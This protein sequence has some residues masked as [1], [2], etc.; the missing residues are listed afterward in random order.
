MAK[1]IQCD[2]RQ[3]TYI[4]YCHKSPNGKRYIGYTSKSL[5]ARSGKNGCGY[6]K[7]K[8]FYSDIVLYGWDNFSHEVL[9]V[10]DTKENAMDLE[11]YYIALYKSTDREHGYNK[12]IGGY[13]CNKG[14]SEEEKKKRRKE[15]IKRW[16]ESHPEKRKEYQ[17]KNDQRP[18]RKARANEL[19]KTPK[20]RQHRTEYMRKYRDLNRDR[21]REIQKKAN[22]RRKERANSSRYST[23]EE[24]SQNERKVV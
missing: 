21:I 6:S 17:R 5:N 10:C 14:L 1:I 13:P 20:R 23:E 15:V 9:S 12:S 7:N 19:N 3:K 22:E 11:I 8:E 4:V 18:E 2:T 24:S 16:S